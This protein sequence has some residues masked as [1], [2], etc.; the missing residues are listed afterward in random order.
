MDDYTYMRKL[1]YEFGPDFSRPEYVDDLCEEILERGIDPAAEEKLLY[2]LNCYDDYFEEL[3]L[4]SFING[5]K[6]SNRI[7]HELNLFDEEIFV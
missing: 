6:L 7:S 3:A 1:L 4:L 5:F 2:I